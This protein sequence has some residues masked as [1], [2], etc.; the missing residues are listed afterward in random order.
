M[1]ARGSA[2]VELDEGTVT[3]RTSQPAEVSISSEL[4]PTG[5]IKAGGRQFTGR[6]RDG[7]FVFDLPAL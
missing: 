3:I 1:R 6:P 4:I 5:R 2:Y 7:K